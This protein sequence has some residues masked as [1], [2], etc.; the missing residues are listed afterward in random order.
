MKHLQKF[1][2]VL[3]NGKEKSK[4][5]VDA[6]RN[7]IDSVADNL[8]IDSEQAIEEAKKSNGVKIIEVWE[9]TKNPKIKPVKKEA[10]KKAE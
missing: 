3:E 4:D 1:K 8:L 10:D 7:I 2:V 5:K 6:S 9:E